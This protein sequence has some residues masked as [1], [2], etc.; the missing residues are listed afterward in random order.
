MTSESILTSTKILII[1][2]HSL[3]RE[4]LRRFLC[5]QDGFQ[6]VGVAAD[7]TSALKMVKELCPDVVLMGFVLPDVPGAEVISHIKRECPNTVLIVLSHYKRFQYVADAVAAG[8]DAI[9]QRASR[10]LTWFPPFVWFVA[11][12]LC[13]TG[14]SPATSF[15]KRYLV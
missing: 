8:A 5:E 13:L 7:G 9:Y 11:A 6:C 12:Y 14:A 1:E 2:E 3:F 4:G 15:A 10:R